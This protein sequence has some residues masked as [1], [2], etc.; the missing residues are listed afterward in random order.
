M[1]PARS[2]ADA[3]W[4]RTASSGQALPV[5]SCSTATSTGT[6]RPSTNSRRTRWPG[7]LGA[8][9]QTSTPSAGLDVAEADVE[10]VAEEQ[11]VARHQVRGRSASAYTCRC[12]WSGASIMITSASSQASAGETTRSPCVLGL[13]PA[14]AALGQADPHVHAGVA[15]A[16][17][18]RVPLAAVADDGDLA[19]PGSRTGRR[20]RRRTSRPRKNISIRWWCRRAGQSPGM[21]GAVLQRAVRV[22]PSAAPGR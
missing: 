1:P 6:P 12:T 11:R 5:A 3:P 14:G 15:Q 9:M 21:R 22:R 13:R 17:R 4:R 8:T 7:P 18:V 19:P 10:A 16:Q 2:A 20:R